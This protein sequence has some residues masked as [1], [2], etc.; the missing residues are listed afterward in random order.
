MANKR[1][2]IVPMTIEMLEFL[3]GVPVGHH[4]ENVTYSPS[5]RTIELHISGDS[6]DET[7]PGEEI[8]WVLPNQLMH[9][10]RNHKQKHSECPSR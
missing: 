10:W 6:M 9:K 4:I 7:Q 1:I 5:R 2:N 3:F 8:R